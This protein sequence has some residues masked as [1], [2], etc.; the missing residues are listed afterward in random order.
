MVEVYDL[1][2]DKVIKAKNVRVKNQKKGTTQWSL[3]PFEL[4]PDID[5]QINFDGSITFDIGWILHFEYTVE[6][7][8]T[9]TGGGGMTY[10]Y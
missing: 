5:V 9:T 1:H 2:G 4:L 10:S 8:E 6:I 7:G 3:H